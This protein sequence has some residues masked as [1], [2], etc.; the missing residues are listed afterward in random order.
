MWLLLCYQ[1]HARCLVLELTYMM[2]WLVERVGGLLVCFMWVGRQLLQESRTWNWYPGSLSQSSVFLCTWIVASMSGTCYQTGL[3][4][5]AVLETHFLWLESLIQASM[6]SLYELL[7]STVS[8]LL[9]VLS[10]CYLP[11][12]HSQGAL[13]ASKGQVFLTFLHKILFLLLI[14][15]LFVFW[16]CSRFEPCPFEPVIGTVPIITMLGLLW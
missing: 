15:F 14:V 1:R 16:V 4:W 8:C 11:N 7:L 2:Q 5:K 9:A 6:C 12:V 10:H 13:A 3:S